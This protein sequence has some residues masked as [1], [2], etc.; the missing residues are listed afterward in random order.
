MLRVWRACDG[1]P[2]PL[3]VSG[4]AQV[5]VHSNDL[6]CSPEG[7]YGC[8]SEIDYAERGHLWGLLLKSTVISTVLTLFS[9]KLLWIQAQLYEDL[10]QSW[11]RL[12]TLRSLTEG[13]LEDQ[14]S[15]AVFTK[16]AKAKSSFSLAELREFPKKNKNRGESFLT[17]R[18]LHLWSNTNW[19]FTLAL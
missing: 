13:S 14:R 15:G 5:L 17:L 7:L 9:C 12:R 2:C 10:S 1:F 6:F 19:Y 4:G 3:P 18:L 8:H 16:H 11:I